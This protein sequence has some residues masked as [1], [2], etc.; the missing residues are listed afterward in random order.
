MRAARNTRDSPRNSAAPRLPPRPWA[1][2][3]RRAPETGPIASSWNKT[4][5]AI[6]AAFTT[7]P[8]IETDDPTSLASKSGKMGP[9]VY[10]G[11]GRLY[12]SQNKPAEAVAQ[13]QKALSISPSDLG[14]MVSLARLYDR[15]GESA[16]AIDYYH[17]A[18]KAN[19]KSALAHN[20]LGLCYARQKQYQQAT[21]SLNKAIAL[22]PTNPKYRNNMATVMVELGRTDEAYKQL[23]AINSEAVAHYNLAYLLE[24]K[25]QNGPAILHLQ[26]AISRDPSLAPAHEMLAQLTGPPQ[27]QTPEGDPQGQ[28]RLAAVPVSTPVYRQPSD[29]QWPPTQPPTGYSQYAPSPSDQTP[30]D[31]SPANA[32]GSGGSYH[33]GD[34]IGPIQPGPAAGH[35]DWGAPTQS[36]TTAPPGGTGVEP[37]P[38]IEG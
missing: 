38:P 32:T 8:K 35:S 28:S 5:S 17:K 36:P 23:A 7:K 34:D 27:G 11:L 37:L 15:R 29:V 2:V 18:I 24:Q 19:P 4:T 14:A 22:Q 9:D 21:E 20:D 3:G 33:I 30:A 12:E 10:V 1:A 25:G 26:Q 16:K 13:Y 31:Q 6:A